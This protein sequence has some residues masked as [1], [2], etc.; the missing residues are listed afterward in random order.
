MN[1]PAFLS[2]IR[3]RLAFTYSVLVFALA[4][5]AVGIVN[6]ALSRSLRDPAVTS[7]THLTTI[8]DPTT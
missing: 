6:V 8:I 2:S 1:I 3:F 5:A 7:G 4:V